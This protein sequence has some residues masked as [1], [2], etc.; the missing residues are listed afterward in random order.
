[1]PRKPTTE[2]PVIIDTADRFYNDTGEWPTV[3]QLQKA[4]G[5]STARANEALRRAKQIRS[6][7]VPPRYFAALCYLGETFPNPEAAMKRLE[8]LEN[9]TR[10]SR[11]T[12]P[13]LRALL[14]LQQPYTKQPDNLTKARLQELTAKPRDMKNALTW[15]QS[16]NAAVEARG[17][18]IDDPHTKQLESMNLERKQR[19]ND[20]G[21]P[22]QQRRT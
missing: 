10:P 7:D 19:A 6:K 2:M 16:F 14:A 17:Q 3:E 8:D 12:K 5:A 11:L 1:M 20:P 4:T 18:K 22:H 21:A 13:E 15:R 9:T